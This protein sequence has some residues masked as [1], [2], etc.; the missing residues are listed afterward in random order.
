MMHVNALC[1]WFRC[2]LFGLP[3]GDQAFLLGNDV[4]HMLGGYD[5]KAEYGEDHLLVWKAKQSGIA[6]VPIGGSIRT[7]ARKYME[8]GWFK[9]TSQH[10]RMF[11]KQAFP[12]YKIYKSGKVK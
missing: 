6:V 9:T 10:F 1:V 7:S 8:N 11:I 2:R 3:F 5:A 12:Q 4:F